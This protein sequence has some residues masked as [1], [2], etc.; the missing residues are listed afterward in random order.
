[1]APVR[2]SLPNQLRSRPSM[3]AKA[4]SDVARASSHQT[5]SGART[6]RA[7]PDIRTMIDD[8]DVICGR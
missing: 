2:T 4:L 5:T 7:R 1:M 8:M 6:N 3:T